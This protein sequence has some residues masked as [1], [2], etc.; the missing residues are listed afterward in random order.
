[1]LKISHTYVFSAKTFRWLT[2]PTRNM[3]FLGIISPCE[4]CNIRVKTVTEVQ[5]IMHL[6]ILD[7]VTVINSSWAFLFP[8][9]N[10]CKS[11]PLM[12]S[13][14]SRC[15]HIAHIAHIALQKLCTLHSIHGR[16]HNDDPCKGRFLIAWISYSSGNLI[17]Y[18]STS[19]KRSSPRIAKL[20][21]YSG[22]VRG[23]HPSGIMT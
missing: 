6:D 9:K 17:H 3:A 2:E 23:G 15:T 1:M 11:I 5:K 4:S 21:Y 13:R 14:Y 12:P 20:I 18:W 8:L 16:V 22:G 10:G 19:T 7:T